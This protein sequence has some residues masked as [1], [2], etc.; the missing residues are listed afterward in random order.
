MCS[1][2]PISLRTDQST[3]RSGSGTCNDFSSFFFGTVFCSKPYITK[4]SNHFYPV[5]KVENT[6]KIL[7]SEFAHFRWALTHGKLFF[8]VFFVCV[9][10]NMEF[11]VKAL[12]TNVRKGP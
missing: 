1:F 3:D 8:F 5:L 2:L 6:P 9:F 12:L 7:T 10:F 4:Q 11:G